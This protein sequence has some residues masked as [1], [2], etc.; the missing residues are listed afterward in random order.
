M[1]SQA[2]AVGEAFACAISRRV[3]E[4]PY[5]YAIGS[6]LFIRDRAFHGTLEK[7]VIKKAIVQTEL[8]TYVDTFNRV[9]LEN[10]LVSEETA[11]ELAITYW[12]QQRENALENIRNCTI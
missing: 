3:V 8:D 9:W 7:V 2:L 11:S 6:T 5:A 1:S 4:L 12:T 10:E